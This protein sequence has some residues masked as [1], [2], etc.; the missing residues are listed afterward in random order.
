MDS[1]TTE[2]PD[3]ADRPVAVWLV[4]TLALTLLVILLLAGLAA[5]VA[6]KG[7]IGGR[8]S[9]TLHTAAVHW[10]EEIV[11]LIRSGRDV[12]ELMLGRTALDQAVIFGKVDSVRLLLEHGAD[13]DLFDPSGTTSPSVGSSGV[14]GGGH[15]PD[16][17]PLGS[18]FLHVNVS[19]PARREIILMLLDAGADPDVPGTFG[20]TILHCAARQQDHDLVERVLAH[21]AD[22]NIQDTQGR[23][24]LHEAVWADD[25]ILVEML[26]DAGAD[27]L[28]EDMFGR[29]P[30]DIADSGI[31]RQVD[32]SI[33]QRLQPEA[34]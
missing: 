33:R 29:K 10:P 15:P 18:P 8:K 4:V 23:T 2:P 14:H 24:P 12:D 13:P 31:A 27:P 5:I 16:R 25:P 26:L 3:V 34:P 28:L 7:A 21:G 32:E 1:P 20:A 19:D 30:A 17:P 22:V 11:P 6:R 9:D